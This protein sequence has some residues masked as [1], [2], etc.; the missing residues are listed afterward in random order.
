V[1]TH[2]DLGACEEDGRA[3]AVAFIMTDDAIVRN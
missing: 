1:A 3:A 2:Q